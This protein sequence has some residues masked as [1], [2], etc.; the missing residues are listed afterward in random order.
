M[1]V[2]EGYDVGN[3]FPGFG[4][5]YRSF[6]LSLDDANTPTF[7]FND[8]LDMTAGYDIVYVDFNNG[9]DDIRRNAALL[10]EVIAWVNANKV[11]NDNNANIME[12]N[13][14]LGISM[15]G[16]VA[17]YAL[18][19]MTK[20]NVE[21]DTRLLITHD[22]PHQGAN[23]PL[24]LQ[25]LIRMTGGIE[26]F[27]Y[28][29]RDI[30]PQYNQTINLLNEE[31]SRQMLIYRSTSINTM[32]AN[33]FLNGDYRN[34]IT[35]ASTDPQP[36]YEFL[37]TSNGSECGNQLFA[38][39]N[40][41]IN[42]LAIARLSVILVTYKFQSTITAK[43]LPALGSTNL[44]TYLNVRSH[45]R[46]FGLINI[47]KDVYE[48]T[49]YAPGTQLPIDGVPGG[50]NPFRAEIPVIRFP[51]APIL[52][53]SLSGN[54]S[55]FSFVPT[56]SALDAAPFNTAAFSQKFVNGTNP[57]FPSSSNNFIAQETNAGASNV[58][59]TLFTARNAN[60]L[61]DE[62]EG[63]ANTRNCSNECSPDYS[64]SGNNPICS[65]E[66]FSINGLQNGATVTWNVSP[67][68][69]VNITASGNQVSIVKTNNGLF[70]LTATIT[71][72]CGS[73]NFI[74]LTRN[75]TAGPLSPYISGPFD[76]IQNTIMNV[77]YVGEQY[78]FIASEYIP[79]SPAPT[80]TW[81][82]TPPPGS[83][84]NVSL[85]SGGTIYLYFN[86]GEGNYTLNLTKTTSCGS[87]SIAIV[88]PVQQN[89]GFRISA[90]PNPTS[91]VLNVTIDNETADVKALKKE[92]NIKI[93]LIDFVTGT[94]RKSWSYKNV[95]NTF[96]LSVANL[97]KGQY[98]IRVSKGSYKQ[99]KQIIIN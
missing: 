34:M 14:V 78:Y 67:K 20:N 12:Q 23:V 81:T 1:I 55:Y 45:L 74:T 26:L 79:E 37:A 35:F 57:S 5:T 46:L 77:A 15:G 4:N 61:F 9:T 29:V 99:T 65:T 27:G 86:D 83:G 16:L 91:D 72:A 89:Y 3:F 88:I 75:L 70:T 8:A 6:I 64:I 62:M 56:V 51:Y 87:N 17:R 90:S 92:E 94:K 48:E 38:P 85:F 42:A 73:T 2:V 50:L 44:I 22:S 36:S 93:D 47:N 95:Q 7:D 49:A 10:E 97:P 98:V 84:G 43:A 69:V 39:Y 96:N 71:D 33:T 58:S 82:L 54:P 11:P 66:V 30:F 40:S 59:H 63:I 68:K 28:T 21:T 53:A 25:Y 31:A 19:E 76:P 60:W 41:F 52:I 18:A 13:V 24:S 80:Y 32:A